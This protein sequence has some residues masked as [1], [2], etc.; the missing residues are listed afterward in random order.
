MEAVKKMPELFPGENDEYKEDL[1]LIRQARYETCSD[2]E[3]I[4][5]CEKYLNTHCFLTEK[6][7]EALKDMR[8]GDPYDGVDTDDEP[9]DDCRWPTYFM[10]IDPHQ[11]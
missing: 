5:S 9:Y 4:N 10:G 2:S 6:Q 8:D 11:G 1:K 7:R 3:F